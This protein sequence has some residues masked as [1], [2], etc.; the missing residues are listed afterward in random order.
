MR[1]TIKS[2]A[3]SVG[4]W[5]LFERLRFL[6][7]F[8]WRYRRIAGFLDIPGWLSPQDAT[9]LYDSVLSLKCEKPVIV[10]IGS[11]LGKSSMVLAQ[12]LRKKG[13][14]IIH[15]IDPFDASGDLGAQHLYEKRKAELRGSLLEAFQ[16]NMAQYALE[17]FVRP[18]KGF[19]HEVVRTFDGEIDMLFIDGDHAYE[20]VRRDFLDWEPR[21]KVGGVLAMHDIYAAPYGD[22]YTGPGRVAKEF[23][24]ERKGWRWFRIK[25]IA[26]FA[27]KIG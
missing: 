3:Q 18:V 17:P 13:G 21:L 27:V 11:H 25:D 4:L 22:D 2:F 6:H 12:A 1:K 19:S 15:C 20:A 26:C 16:L 8:G 10:E 23:I 14:G 24:T 7:R 9:E 5:S